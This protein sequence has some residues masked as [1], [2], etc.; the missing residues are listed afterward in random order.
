MCSVPPVSG[1]RR[2]GSSQ[3]HAPVQ[4][5]RDGA[6]GKCHRRDEPSPGTWHCLLHGTPTPV[7]VGGD[8]LKSQSRSLSTP[9]ILHNRGGGLIAAGA[10][11]A[12]QIYLLH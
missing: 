7:A 12:S 10:S 9:T 1:G 6:Q 3:L 4:A 8:E 11:N 5:P 2:A